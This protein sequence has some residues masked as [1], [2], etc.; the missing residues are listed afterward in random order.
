MVPV[1]RIVSAIGATGLGTAGVVV[2]GSG[3]TPAQGDTGTAAAS[4]SETQAQA[5]QSGQLTVRTTNN[6]DGSTT[7]VYTGSGGSSIESVSP[8]PGF[9]PL[10]ATSDQLK[11]YGF[12][13]RPTTASALADWTQ[14]MA[15]YKS[16]PIPKLVF[17]SGSAQDANLSGNAQSPSTASPA[18]A[19]PA[20]TVN[21]T[22]NYAGYVDTGQFGDFDAAAGKFQA[23]NLGA[24][25]R[26]TLATMETCPSGRGLVD[27]S[28]PMAR[29]YF[30]T[31]SLPAIQHPG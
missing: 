10:S 26:T 30:R 25:C 5:V 27:T 4:G 1:R 31:G 22:G 6:A 14:A 12:P 7:T 8:P 17:S 18:S 9:S 20:A 24:Y 21:A 19:S 11:L 23:P 3:A 28:P 29:T 2:M 15:A 16:S 13:P